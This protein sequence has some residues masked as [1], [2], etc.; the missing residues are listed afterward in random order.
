MLVD[1]D[2]LTG[3][4]LENKNIM[5]YCYSGNFTYFLYS[6]ALGFF[7]EYCRKKHGEFIILLVR[8]PLSWKCVQ[9]RKSS[10]FL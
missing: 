2:N 9:Q 6:T 8:Q 1:R 10:V 7:R 5:I 4:L 3:R